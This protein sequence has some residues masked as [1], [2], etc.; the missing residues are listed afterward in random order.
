[1]V[2]VVDRIGNNASEIPHEEQYAGNLH[3]GFDEG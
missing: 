3:V 2:G 1:M